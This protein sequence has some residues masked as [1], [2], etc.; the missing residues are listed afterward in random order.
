MSDALDVA[1]T[2]KDVS[3]LVAELTYPPELSNLSGVAQTS[4][5]GIFR[6]NEDGEVLPTDLTAIIVNGAQITTDPGFPDRWS[7]DMDLSTGA[8]VISIGYQSV[9]SP[10]TSM[11]WTVLNNV[12]FAVPLDVIPDVTNQRLLV[13]D[14]GL[15]ECCISTFFPFGARLFEVSLQNGDMTEIGFGTWNSA[16]FGTPG[17][18]EI[19]AVN[20]RV[21]FLSQF[22][23]REL[24]DISLADGTFTSIAA[25]NQRPPSQSGFADVDVNSAGSTAFL[26][27]WASPALVQSVSLS[28]SAFTTISGD[29]VGAGPELAQPV[30]LEL[31]ETGNRAIVFDFE[32]DRLMAIDLA[33][34]DRTTVSDP[35]QGPALRSSTTVQFTY[36]LASNFTSG[37]AVMAAPGRNDLV[38]IDMATG[39]R[40]VMSSPSVG[41]GVTF[42]NLRGAGFDETTN[43]LFV[44]DSGR[45]TVFEV[46]PATGDRAIVIDTGVGAGPNMLFPTAIRFDSA[47]SRLI[48]LDTGASGLPFPDRDAAVFAVSIPGGDRVYI[49]G[50]N[51]GSGTN[52]GEAFHFDEIFEENRILVASRNGL[53]SVNLQT[54][55]RTVVSSNTVGTGVTPFIP[56]AVAA[57]PTNDRAFVL[58]TVADSVV[59]VDLS[60][61]SRMTISSAAVGSGP[62][63]DLP[64]SEML[65]DAEGNRIFVSELTTASI[66]QVDLDTGDRSV[67]SGSGV[68]QGN[69]L[70]VVG[71]LEINANGDTIYAAE[72][73]KLIAIDI[74]TGDTTTISRAGGRDIV[75]LHEQR[76][77]Y[78]TTE[79]GRVR[80]ID[81]D[82]GETAIL[83][84]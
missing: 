14:G 19:D 32:T 58:D 21:I 18:A 63:F 42:H 27:E 29:G 59:E 68:G 22:T 67:V 53:I 75:L 40:D 77:L 55:D 64:S 16:L 7:V 15:V 51:R 25:D 12:D 37:Q 33:T 41:S 54:G 62:N 26:V 69:P 45:D 56:Y 47:N 2:V 66:L 31:D 74:A 43:R 82:S 38:Q 78:A 80:V 17:R 9:G 57:D 11:Q 71:G 50:S 5:R 8:N 28:T 30:S 73:N 13:V 4:V 34:G 10:Q 52:L 76:I 23:D 84:D 35:A 39:A 20:N 61:G 1:I 48:V 24:W 36:D 81:I 83:S 72:R 3:D 60:S 46:D 70:S 79:G 6:D 44:V 65:F 49:S